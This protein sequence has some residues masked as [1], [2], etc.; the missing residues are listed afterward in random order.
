[1]TKSVLNFDSLAA[2]E[3]QHEPF[4][5]AFANRL[6]TAEDAEV[7]ARTYP[8]DHYKSV[9][10]LSG[11]EKSYTY[12]ARPLIHIDSTDVAFEDH[13]SDTW[14]QLAR[15]LASPAYRT[16]MSRLTGLD[17]STAPMEA[18]V[19]HFGPGAWLG[20]HADLK[21]KILTHVFYF[22]S[23]WRAEDGGCLHVLRTKNED[24]KVDTVLPLV[25]NS[26][27]IMRSDT[28]WHSVSKVESGATESRRSMNVIFYNGDQPS[29]M[30]PDGETPS[31]HDYPPPAVAAE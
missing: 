11:G 24:D 19:C 9:A 15:D 30:W 4:D 21:T 26:S 8:V 20:P 18:Y 12:E 10:R 6:Y 7:L 27:I 28:S 23:E 2:T 1:M 3:L 5:W 14:R 13:L 29:S 25:G 17:L 31:F 16:A 22:N